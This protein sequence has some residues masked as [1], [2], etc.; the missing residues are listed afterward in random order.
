MG[1]E[2]EIKDLKIQRFIV[3]QEIENLR[4]EESPD[5]L[6]RAL[7]INRAKEYGARADLL[8]MELGAPYA[9]KEKLFKFWKSFRFF[10]KWMVFAFLLGAML[11][12][13]QSTSERVWPRPNIQ[14]DVN[15]LE[16]E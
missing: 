11:A 4:A 10:I 5:K 13:G 15:Y 14:M 6:E 8:K 2:A 1:V 12:V 3:A 16:G 9:V 7:H